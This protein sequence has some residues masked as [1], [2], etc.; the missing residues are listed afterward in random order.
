MPAR[1]RRWR[2]QPI[3]LPGFPNSLLF[4]RAGATGYIGTSNGLASLNTA[5]NVVNADFTRTDRQSAGGFGGWKSGDYF[6]RGQRSLH[7]PAH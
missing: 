2:D 5:T 3:F 1:H 7:R 6:Q 4:D